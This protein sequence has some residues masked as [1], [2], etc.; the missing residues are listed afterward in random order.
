MAKKKS[1]FS[2]IANWIGKK[3]VGTREAVSD[4]NPLARTI[5]KVGFVTIEGSRTDFQTSPFNFDDIDAGY[6]TDSYVRQALDKYIE[7]MFKAG[8][9]IKYKSERVK[10]YMTK[11]LVMLA[12]AMGI[13]IDQFFKEI[14]EDLVKYSNVFLAKARQDPAKMAKMPNV[15]VR[16]LGGK[17]PV[18]GYFRQHPSTMSIKVDQHGTI[19]KYKQTVNDNEK[20]FNPEDI[21][22]IYYKKPAGRFFG[23]PLALPVLDDVRL[24][25]EVEDNVARLIYRHLNPLYLYRVGLDK[26]GYEATDDE[27]EEMQEQIR[28]MPT[29]GGLVVPERHDVKVIGAERQALDAEKYL[30]YFERRVFTGFG[31]PETVMGRGDTSNRSTAETQSVEMR[32]SVEAYQSVFE[33]FVNH[34]IMRELLMEGGF[35]PV[36]NPD[37]I[38]LFEFNEIDADLEIKKENH[39]IFKYEHNAI[40]HEE[41]RLALGYEPVEDESRLC[42]NMFGKASTADTDNRE[43]PTNQHSQHLILDE[44]NGSSMENTILS[45][46]MRARSEILD[47]IDFYFENIKSKKQILDEMNYSLKSAEKQMTYYITAALNSIYKKGYNQGLKELMLDSEI[48]NSHSLVGERVEVYLS[49]FFD[50]LKNKLSHVFNKEKELHSMLAYLSANFDSLEYKLTYLSRRLPQKVYNFGYAMAGMKNGVKSIYYS[51]NNLVREIKLTNESNV[52]E[53]LPS[54][55]FSNNTYLSYKKLNRREVGN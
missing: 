7:L 24:L 8:W 41:M 28:D 11:R 49:E 2:R 26:P 43:N 13:P 48:A 37:D 47:N 54:N 50:N 27:I 17:K 16:G 15:T 1:I 45:V 10:D 20:Q 36:L 29:E 35:D 39:I 34:F 42:G 18:A 51:N 22:H 40:T 14:A 52:F 44:F 21:I 23:I 4:D 25:R 6:N 38:A 33:N 5:K 55:T 12:D 31:T 46:Y 19:K 32:D 3:L 9:K 53:K 30:K